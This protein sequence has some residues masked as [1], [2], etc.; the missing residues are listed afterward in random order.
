MEVHSV[1]AI[2]TAF[3]A[4]SVQYLIVGGLAAVARGYERFTRDVDLV[5]GLEPE[6]VA[7]GFHALLRI[8]YQMAVP[9][10]P[11]EFSNQQLRETWRKE[12]EMV[13]LKLCSDL[14]R[15]TPVWTY[16]FASLSISRRNMRLQSG[17][18]SW[19]R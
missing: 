3:N 11:E 8:G 10:S 7:R 2:I 6:N 19:V 13:V 9:V 16:S 17:R 15:R 5:I 18:K 4:A 1:E 12:K 14:H